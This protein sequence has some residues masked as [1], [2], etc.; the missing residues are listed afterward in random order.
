MFVCA[1]SVRRSLGAGLAVVCI[2]TASAIAA[3]A[4]PALGQPVVAGPRVTL[5]WS[6]SPGAAGYRLAIGAI[7][8]RED[9]ARV[10]GNVTTVSFT[11]PFTGTG[12]VRAQAFDAS[13]LSA[14]S[15]EVIVT[16]TTMTPVPSAP[17]NL[18]AVLVGR[19]VALSWAA[20]PGG[21]PPLG[22]LVEA[23]TAPGAG[24]IGLVPVPLSTSVTVPNVPPGTYFVRVYGV[25]GSGRS[26]ASN[27][28]RVDM[29]VGGGCNAPGA[30]SLSVS[31]SGRD[32][33]MSW[34]A[35]AGV[36][37][38]RL[39]VASASSGA[40]VFTQA[41]GAGT[42]T[43]NASNAPPGDYHARIITLTACG[44][45]TASEVVSFS[46]TSASGGGPRTPDPQPGRR[47][48][49]P[50]MSS[51]VDSVGSAYRGD[52]LNSCVEHGGNNTW[53]FRLVEELRR[54]DTRWGLN[55]KRGRVGDMSQDV[56]T[57]NYSADPDEGT[58]NVY[59]LD[60]ISGHCGNNPTAGWTDVTD[61]TIRSGTIGRWTLQPY[62]ASG[63]TP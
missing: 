48:P 25:N 34:A 1:R 23:G 27:E 17:V 63:R 29:P 20:G 57:Y 21:G 35:I 45:E 30:S 24:N 51:V 55:W 32:V 54:R 26:R 19:S 6:A 15:N 5:T 8:G 41:Y 31:T 43:L 9:Y 33:A 49:L 3:P 61:V 12:Y 50:D 40:I 59:I 42:T 18:Q 16:V 2:G 47:L 56:V 39:D 10:V 22:M 53:L 7:P 44:A 11:A 60:V 13:G 37:G 52:L 36:A 58:T 4:P 46:I 28:V 62:I 38:Y 14:P